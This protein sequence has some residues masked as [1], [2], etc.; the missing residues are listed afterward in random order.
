MNQSKIE[1]EEV[2]EILI[3]SDE[4][5][6]RVAII[7]DRRLVEIYAERSSSFSSVGNIYLGKIKDVLPGMEAAFV[8]IGL[9]K[10]GFL[11]VDEVIFP[12]DAPDPAN[13]KIQDVLKK[14]QDIL[15]QVIKDPMGTKGARVTTHIS[16]AG[17]YLVLMVLGGGVG[18]S[19]K[20]PEDER[21]R[22][23]ELAATIKPKD[24]GMIVR[25]DAEDA[26]L[27]D[28]KKDLNY[29]KTTWKEIKSRLSKAKA[30]KLVHF[31]EEL[32]LKIVRDVFSS[33]FKN[34]IVDSSDKFKK[35]TSYLKKA[36]PELVGSVSLFSDGI[37]LFEKYGID[38]QI[39]DSLERKVWLRSG[40]HLTID[41]T[42]ALTTIDVNT[43]KY[44]GKTSLEETIIKTNMEAVVEVVRQ[45]RLRDIGG[46]IVIDFIDMTESKNRKKV[47]KA[48]GEALAK[49]RTKSKVVEISKL[50]LIEMTRKNVTEGLSG[51]VF[52]DCPCC[53][54]S[55]KVKSSETILIELKRRLLQFAVSNS[56]KAFI[57]KLNPKAA[58]F[59]MDDGAIRLK[60]LKKKSGKAIYLVEDE[61]VALDDFIVSAKGNRFNLRRILA[62]ILRNSD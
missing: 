37:P 27:G 48:L 32:A 20:L 47:S 55:G 16:L 58:R 3:S 43:G 33:D 52:E 62:G 8:D 57:F 45:I 4:D 46:M 49:D 25:T 53:L 41:R 50:G 5:E 38:S 15:V 6:T 18:L 26:T 22:L 40:G 44:I 35:I 10:N 34:L 11:Y 1:L 19:K 17:K 54:G 12:K 28:L 56:E 13:L 36:N 2:K 24:M 61:E 30:P 60:G 39:E 29:L 9:A 42:E 31:E 59:L 14:G 21:A 7:E 23:K 51:I